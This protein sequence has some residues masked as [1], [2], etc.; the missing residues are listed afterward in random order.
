ML[1]LSTHLSI[2]HA[3]Y[4]GPFHC[5]IQRWWIRDLNIF[6]GSGIRVWCARDCLPAC[7]RLLRL[8]FARRFVAQIL[9]VFREGDRSVSVCGACLS[10][11]IFCCCCETQCCYCCL[12]RPEFARCVDKFL[13]QT[14]ILLVGR[15]G[16]LWKPKHT[17]ERLQ[18]LFANTQGC[19]IWVKKGRV[20]E[21]SGN[22][23]LEIASWWWW[24]F[25]LTL[26]VFAVAFLSEERVGVISSRESE[27][28]L[29][30]P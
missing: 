27:T 14:R 16:L 26:N 6:W 10:P 2:P 3:V 25:F 5:F 30:K 20:F 9:I 23:R 29:Q 15:I 24:W 13:S 7:L 21:S 17:G 4:S 12:V 8:C 22:G 11:E 18:S 28:K 19:G 1:F